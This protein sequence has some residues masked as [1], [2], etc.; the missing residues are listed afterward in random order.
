MN[1]TLFSALDAWDSDLLF[2]KQVS[3]ISACN[4]SLTVV[5]HLLAEKPSTSSPDYRDWNTALCWV[6]VIN[7]QQAH[8][9]ET[10]P[11]QRP[12]VESMFFRRCVPAGYP[13]HSYTVTSQCSYVST[14]ERQ[15]DYIW[16]VGMAIDG[17]QQFDLD[18][19]SLLINTCPNILDK[20]VNWYVFLT[21]K[22]SQWS[23]LFLLPPFSYQLTVWHL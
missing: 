20:Y 3:V 21:L 14:F 16:T 2:I 12:D 15:F 13:K 9:V 7:T 23:H 1:R 22:H 4:G 18:L 10:T 19:H 17:D 8:N 5:R 6:R 11:I